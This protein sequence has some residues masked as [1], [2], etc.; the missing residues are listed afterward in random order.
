V[1]LKHVFLSVDTHFISIAVANYIPLHAH[2]LT[3]G[4]IGPALQFEF[5]HQIAYLSSPVQ[6]VPSSDVRTR[7]VHLLTI[8]GIK[9]CHE[10]EL[11]SGKHFQF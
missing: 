4:L 2:F 11:R 1:S 7:Y 8:C 3:H 9:L 10:P 6:V 5:A